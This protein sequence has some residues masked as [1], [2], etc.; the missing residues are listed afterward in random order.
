MSV[1]L[2][3]MEVDSRKLEKNMA[4][5]GEPYMQRLDYKDYKTIIN[6]IKSVFVSLA[7]PGG[8]SLSGTGGLGGFGWVLI[9]SPTSKKSEK[10]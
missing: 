5:L 2:S 10:S 1:G 4:T 6:I 3:N 9:P 7:T 8:A